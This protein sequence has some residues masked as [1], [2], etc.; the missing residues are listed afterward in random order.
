MFCAKW[1]SNIHVHATDAAEGSDRPSWALDVHAYVLQWVD[2]HLDIPFSE[3]S[4]E[5]TRCCLYKVI[6]GC[7]ESV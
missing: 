2:I 3:K 6:E 4:T 7:M 5:R 1:N